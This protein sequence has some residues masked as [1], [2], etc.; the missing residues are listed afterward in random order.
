[1][2]SL[3]VK[4][5]T[6]K[7]SLSS[8]AVVAPSVVISHFVRRRCQGSLTSRPCS[9]FSRSGSPVPDT[10]KA[11]RHRL[12]R[13]VKKFLL[14]SRLLFAHIP[15]ECDINF[16]HKAVISTFTGGR[17]VSFTSLTTRIRWLFMKGPCSRFVPRTRE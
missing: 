14:V 10:P 7:F 12:V 15:F 11:R 1:M 17:G 3:A 5:F 8:R 9:V 16:P 13:D 2:F 6:A 4:N